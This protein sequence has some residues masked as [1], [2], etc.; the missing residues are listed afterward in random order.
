MCIHYILRQLVELCKFCLDK[1]QKQEFNKKCILNC[2]V[3]SVKYKGI[4]L[5]S[6]TIITIT[7]WHTIVE[8][9]KFDLRRGQP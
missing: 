4:F 5:R 3:K 8:N 6:F 2:G 9:M 1:A 7:P